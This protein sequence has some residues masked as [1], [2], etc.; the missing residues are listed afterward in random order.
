VRARPAISPAAASRAERPSWRSIALRRVMSRVTG[1]AQRGRLV[2]GR[3]D[4]E[5]D[6]KPRAVSAHARQFTR[7]AGARGLLEFG[8]HVIHALAD[9]IA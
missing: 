1:N 2:F 6:R 9:Q 4:G 7:F 8:Q 3:A 5:L